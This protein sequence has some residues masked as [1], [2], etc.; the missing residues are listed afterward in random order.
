MRSR[1]LSVAGISWS[2]ARWRAGAAGFLSAMPAICTPG[3]W[4]RRSSSAVP[5]L[6]PPKIATLVAGNGPIGESVRR[7]GGLEPA[8]FTHLHGSCHR[9]PQFLGLH[10]FDQVVGHPLPEQGSGHVRI[11]ES[12]EHDQGD[13][14]ILAAEVGDGLHAVDLWHTDV[15]D[16]YVEHQAVFARVE[17]LDGLRAILGFED[18]IAGLVQHHSNEFAHIGLIIRHEYAAISGFR[19]EEKICHDSLP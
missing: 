17:H 12:G 16:D 7:D 6:P 8:Q 1:T 19:A 13:P 15:T 3:S 2:L 11:R 4:L 18:L 14:G 9:S 5:P 10:R